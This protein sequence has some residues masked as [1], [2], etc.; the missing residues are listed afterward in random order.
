MASE[1]QE[2]Y[3]R[4]SRL[5]DS[6]ANNQAQLSVQ[7]NQFSAQLAELAARQAQFA[8]DLERLKEIAATHTGA[9]RPACR[10]GPQPGTRCGGAGR[11]TDERLRATDERLNVLIGVVER[12]FSNGRQE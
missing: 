1:E 2:R 7:Q 10:Y 12:Y 6:L 8:A 11:R 3:G 4:I 5:L 9:D